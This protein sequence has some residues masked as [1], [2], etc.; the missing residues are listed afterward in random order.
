VLLSYRARSA[1]HQLKRSARSGADIFAEALKIAVAL[2]LFMAIPA[3]LFYWWWKGRDAVQPP[4][5][6]PNTFTFEGGA[7]AAR[8]EALKYLDDLGKKRWSDA[9]A[10]LSSGWRQEISLASFEE[11]FS[12]IG[13]IRW[14]VNDQK[15]LPGGQADVSLILAFVEDGRAKKFQGRFRL[16]Q[17]GQAWKVDRVELSSPPAR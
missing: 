15:L 8:S 2:L 16:A 11:A 7:L 13:D 5:Q 10:R 17:E 14:A 3:G 1:G 4:L 9:Y 6:V 12:G